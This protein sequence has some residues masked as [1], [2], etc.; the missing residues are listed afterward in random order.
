MTA[1]LNQRQLTLVDIAISNDGYIIPS[2]KIVRENQ[3][4]LRDIM[5]ECFQSW[6][7][8]CVHGQDDEVNLVLDDKI[9]ILYET[10]ET[11]TKTSKALSKQKKF[12]TITNKK[13][14]SMMMELAF[15]CEIFVDEDNG[16]RFCFNAVETCHSKHDGDNFTH[17]NKELVDLLCLVAQSFI[18][19]IYS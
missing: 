10:F 11:L 8:S 13:V 19:I 4:T 5:N 3:A 2:E 7:H 6:Y 9:E 14:L 16:K 18:N 17:F 1:I 12:V 15:A